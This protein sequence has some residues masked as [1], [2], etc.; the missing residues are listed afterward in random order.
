ML[1]FLCDAALGLY[2]HLPAPHRGRDRIVTF[3]QSRARSRW[4]GIRRFTR[5]GVHLESDFTV[6][7][8]GWTLYSYGC[9]DYYDEKAIRKMLHPG[10]VCLDVGAHIGYFSLLFSHL[11]GSTGR[12]ISFEPIPYTHSFLTRNIEHNQAANV[13]V[14]HAAVGNHIG[15]ARMLAAPNNRLGWS[16]ISDQGDVDVRC[17]TIDSEVLRLGIPRL[18]LV[19]M[20]VEGYELEVLRGAAQTIDKLR[21]KVM[22]EV[23]EHALTRQGASVDAINNFFFDR[24]YKLYKAEK[25]HL[26]PIARLNVEAAFFNI[27]AIPTPH[28]GEPQ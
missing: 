8:V 4:H 18:H 12:I 25:G 17:T 11:V 24:H 7:D 5:R 20:D 2:G 21:P 23:N 19:K 1:D 3:L 13:T 14:E 9:L 28:S 15:V 27:F 22:F 16:T 10:D 26:R 6:D